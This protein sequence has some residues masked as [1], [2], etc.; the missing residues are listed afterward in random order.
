MPVVAN[1]PEWNDPSEPNVW[2]RAPAVAT[3]RMVS[4]LRASEAF[5]SITG[6]AMSAANARAVEVFPVPGGPAS[7]RARTSGTPRVHASAHALMRLN[8]GPLPT[9]SASDRGRYFSVQSNAR[10]TRGTDMRDGARAVGKRPDRRTPEVPHGTGAK[11]SNVQFPSGSRSAVRVG[12]FWQTT[13]PP[14]SV[15]RPCELAS[16]V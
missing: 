9:T 7:T 14:P 5:S 12:P 10:A 16:T 1:V 13:L 2:L 6:H 4:A 15:W 3:R 11:V 8:A